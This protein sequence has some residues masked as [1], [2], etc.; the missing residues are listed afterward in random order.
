MVI[1]GSSKAYN[2]NSVVNITWE[3]KQDNGGMIY[4]LDITVPPHTEVVTACFKY[5]PTF[6]EDNHWIKYCF[7]IERG[8]GSGSDLKVIKV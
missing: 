3:K 1:M 4:D 7:Q 2:P 8:F 5:I 6:S